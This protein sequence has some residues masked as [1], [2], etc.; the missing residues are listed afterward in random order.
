MKYLGVMTGTSCDGIDVACLEASGGEYNTLAAAFFQY[1]E[2]L[3][4]RLLGVIAGQ[5]QTAAQFNQLDAELGQAYG[6]AVQSFLKQH[7]WSH[8]DIQCMGLHG[9]TIDH[10]PTLNTWQIG[11]AQHVATITGIDVVA[12]FRTQ[13]V[14]LG[15]QGAPLAPAIHQALFADDRCRVVLNLG[16][17]ANITVLRGGALLGFD[18]GPANCL[19]DAWADEHLGECCDLGGQWAAQGTVN[20]GLLERLLADP[21]FAL[22]PPK[23][24]GRE[25][26]NTAWLA[27]HLDAVQ[28][29][30]AVDVQATLAALTVQT[31]VYA[32]KAQ[33][34]EASQVVVCGGGVHND[35]LM[36]A[37]Q[38]NLDAPVVS[39][40]AL[41]FDPDAMEALLM[42]WLACAHDRGEVT[43]L[44]AVTGTQK[45]LVYGVRFKAT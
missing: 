39:S 34:P 14:T 23:S 32:I 21:Y 42:A 40:A 29:I 37:L 11:S 22:E 15:G 7:N 27:A 30:A 9:Q 25:Y 31:V 13:D 33:V 10:Q 6:E 3:R 12:D 38:N 26:F 45:A 17:I 2:A 8:H 44:R 5:P 19:M 1:P 4:Q 35:H 28:A 16:G 41:G 24:T 18:T 43:D 20:G 36:N